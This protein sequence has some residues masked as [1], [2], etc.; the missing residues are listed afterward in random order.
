MASPNRAVLLAMAAILS[1]SSAQASIQIGDAAGFGTGSLTIDTDT[2]LEWLDW[3]VSAGISYN[4]MITKFD[5]DETY[6]GWRHA[7]EMK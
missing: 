2:G 5:V 6:E 1:C 3:T 4:D 7:T